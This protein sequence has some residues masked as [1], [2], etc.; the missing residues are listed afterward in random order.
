MEGTL[1]ELPSEKEECVWEEVRKG[2]SRGEKGKCKGPEVGFR[3][4]HYNYDEVGGYLGGGERLGEEVQPEEF[5]LI[6]YPY[7]YY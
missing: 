3:L 2:I 1:N 5:G 7:K 4:V 6:L